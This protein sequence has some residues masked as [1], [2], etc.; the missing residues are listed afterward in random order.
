MSELYSLEYTLN[1]AYDELKKISIQSSKINIDKPVV[2]FSNK[3]TYISNFVTICEKL[4]RKTEE[5]QIYCEEELSVKSSIDQNNCLILPGRFKIDGI[6]KVFDS[7]IK[8]FVTCRECSSCDTILNKENRILF[9][10]CNK[11]KS[12]KAI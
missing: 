1:R 8:Q 12:K 11:C 10:T 6:I 4:K 3:K 5:V 9:I 2:N 7:Y